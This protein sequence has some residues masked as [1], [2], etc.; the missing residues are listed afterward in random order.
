[1]E[2]LWQ[3]FT[4]MLNVALIALSGAIHAQP[5]WIMLGHR[6]TPPLDGTQWKACDPFLVAMAVQGLCMSRVSSGYLPVM[7]RNM[8]SL[9]GMNVLK[10]IY[11][12]F[13]ST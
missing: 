3:Y 6:R 9:N 12:L 4:V 5:G 1:M 2:L 11:E 7:T 13:P 8:D 10:Q